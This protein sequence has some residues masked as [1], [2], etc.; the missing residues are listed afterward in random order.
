MEKQ[1]PKCLNRYPTTMAQCPLD[2]TPLG[3]APAL[4]GPGDMVEG[5]YTILERLGEGGMGVVYRAEQHHLNRQVA[6]K[7][8]RQE[9]H[10]RDEAV[11]RFLTE[12]QAIASL[13]S[14]H[15][16]TLF[17]FGIMQGGALYYT[18]ELLQGETLATLLK[19]EGP[20]DVARAMRIVAH[21]CDSLEEAHERSILHRDIKPEN[22][23]ITIRDGKEWVKVVDFGIAKIAERDAASRNTLD[24]GVVG[25]PQYV[26][27][28]QALGNTVGP[29]ADV[30]SLGIVLYEML[31]GVTPF[32]R[33][34]PMK[35][36]LA[37][38]QDALPPLKSANPSVQLP[39]EVSVLL[40][41]ALEKSPQLRFHSAAAFRDAARKVSD[42]YVSDMGLGKA[43]SGAAGRGA[44]PTPRVQKVRIT[45]Q[46]VISPQPV[47]LV[48]TLKGG[49]PNYTTVSWVSRVSFSP[50]LMAVAVGSKHAA[51]KAIRQTGE[52]T[53][54]TP[55][56]NLVK[57]VDYCGLVS[58][59]T[60]SKCDIF[61][62][63]YGVLKNAPMIQE[64]PL[65]IECRVNEIISLYAYDLFI[66][67][68]VGVYSEER[69]LTDDKPDMAKMRPIALSTAD[70]KYW[71]MGEPLGAAWK[72]GRDLRS[73]DKEN[74]PEP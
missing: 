50:P 30:Y 46:A 28:E 27:P 35:T 11:R 36:M 17:D 5:R 66:G 51:N 20:L 24:G 14:Q 55:S 68:I 23:F 32:Q 70:S 8:L 45:N 53:V 34:T 13:N 15:T 7:V 38:I 72:I 61:T 39:P 6:L 18:M 21:V 37:H 74:D 29:M 59:E 63:F 19:R 48:G 40:H 47:V 2:G 54:N 3:S 69:Y 33:E 56:V 44:S 58:G 1:C 52:F 31:T 10:I 9:M 67:E 43:S 12:A 41:K 73:G 25:T 22:L 65:S 4:L 42:A 60:T 71:S 16:V 49:K 64:C 57:Q 26:S 62:P